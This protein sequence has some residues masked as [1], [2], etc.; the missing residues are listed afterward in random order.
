MHAV[1]QSVQAFS[2]FDSAP[3]F[4][5]YI[6]KRYIFSM[7]PVLLTAT[8]KKANEQ[9][10][11]LTVSARSYLGDGGLSKMPIKKG[12]VDDLP[13]VMFNNHLRQQQ[14]HHR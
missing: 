11:E 6:L 4:F 7:H 9:E 1:S 5:I 8:T 3:A 2:L 12:Y 13:A 14:E 10:A